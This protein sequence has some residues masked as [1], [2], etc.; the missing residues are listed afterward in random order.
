MSYVSI[1]IEQSLGIRLRARVM[2]V[3]AGSMNKPAFRKAS[4]LPQ[5]LNRRFD[6]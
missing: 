5:A 1:S 4:R 3:N 6:S 2:S